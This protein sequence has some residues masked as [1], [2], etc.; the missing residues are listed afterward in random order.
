MLVLASILHC[1]NFKIVGNETF[2]T[3]DLVSAEPNAVN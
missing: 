3:F 1:L 2:Y